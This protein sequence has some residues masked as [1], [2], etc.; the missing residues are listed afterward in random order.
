MA[1]TTSFCPMGEDP[2]LGPEP[3]FVGTPDLACG[4]VFTQVFSK[5]CPRGQRHVFKKMTS[6][7]QFCSKVICASNFAHG[8]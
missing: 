8:Y 1:M 2:Y 5:N 6:F 4:L 3:R 7:F